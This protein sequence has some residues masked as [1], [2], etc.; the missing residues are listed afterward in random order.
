MTTREEILVVKWC[1]R[2][3]SELKEKIVKDNAFQ[4][5]LKYESTD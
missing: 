3:D 2:A 4:I 5:G 1:L